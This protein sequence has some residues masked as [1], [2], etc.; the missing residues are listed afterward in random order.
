MDL[1]QPA[2]PSSDT[3]EPVKGSP[4]PSDWLFLVLLAC[5]MAGVVWVGVLAYAEGK[6]TETVK[7]HGE[8]WG[9]FFKAQSAART[10]EGFEPAVCASRTDPKTTWGECYQALVAPGGALDDLDNPFAGGPQKLV[11]QCSSSDLGTA[12]SL[13][14][15]KM[16]PTPPGSPVPAVAEPLLEE[17]AIAQKLQIRITVCDKGGSPI[18]IGEFE[19]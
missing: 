5:I 8:A 7:R 4:T 11:A 10:Q 16:M 1:A 3:P 14:L 15:E 19:F 13:V 18:R 6:K 12:G 17:D 2:P 9:Q